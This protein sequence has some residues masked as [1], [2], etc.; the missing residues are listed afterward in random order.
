[1]NG[2]VSESLWIYFV[3]AVPGT[4]IVLGTWWFFDSRS[5]RQAETGP[6]DAKEQT[7]AEVELEARI[8]QKI[9]RRTG[10]KVTET[11]ELASLR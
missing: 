3:L 7:K 6:E 11:I 4:V 8:M 10:I 5:R 2:S 9:R 1:M